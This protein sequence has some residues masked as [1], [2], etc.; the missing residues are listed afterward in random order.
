MSKAGCAQCS[1]MPNPGKGPQ[2]DFLSLHIPAHPHA[3]ASLSTAVQNRRELRCGD[4]QTWGLP[5]VHVG[6]PLA[7]LSSQ[8]TSS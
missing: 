7:S 5:S 4:S 1:A 8:L 6:P 3:A 2:G